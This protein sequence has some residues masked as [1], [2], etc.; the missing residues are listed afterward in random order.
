MLLAWNKG[1]LP[2]ES[3][4]GLVYH[5][6]VVYVAL[7]YMGYSGH[8]YC[9]TRHAEQRLPAC[10]LVRTATDATRPATS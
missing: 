10:P 2:T 1:K 7:I 3:Y 8:A 5:I 9:A 6:L 4:K